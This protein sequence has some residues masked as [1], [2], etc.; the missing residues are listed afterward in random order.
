MK[1]DEILIIK[2][3]IK[4]QSNIVKL[5]NAVKNDVAKKTEFD[6]LVKHVNAIHTTD[7]SNLL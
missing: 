4:Q 3:R 7:A 6:E 5:S 1:V 2:K